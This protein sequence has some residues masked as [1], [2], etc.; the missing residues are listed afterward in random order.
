MSLKVYT[1][2]IDYRGED[3]FDITRK[4]ATGDGLALA[5]STKR[6]AYP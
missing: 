4:S 1:A 2:R 6:G 3:R 5:A